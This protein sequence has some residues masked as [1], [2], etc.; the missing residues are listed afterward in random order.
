M[1]KVPL[2]C[3]VRNIRTLRLFC[4]LVRRE[5]VEGEREEGIVVLSTKYND[6]CVRILKHEMRTILSNIPLPDHTC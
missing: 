6:H 1:A 2:I 4:S 3:S 5:G